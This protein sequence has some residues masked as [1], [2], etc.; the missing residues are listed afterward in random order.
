M[1]IELIENRLTAL[2]GG[3]WYE[4]E[5]ELS[6]TVERP[7]HRVDQQLPNRTAEDDGFIPKYGL[8]LQITE[9][10]MFY[11]IYSE[12]YRV[13]GT[14]RGRGLDKG[15]PTLPVVY[16]S[17]IIENTEFGLK[18][19]FADGRV[20]FN[21][22]Y[23][24]MQWQDMQIEVTDPSFNLGIPFQIVV[25]NVGDA[26]VKG[27]DMELKALLGENLEV[28][29]NLTEI[30]DAYVEAPAFYDEPRAEGGKI[31]SGL[32][33]ES[34]LPLFADKS[35]S[36]YMEYSGISMAGGDGALRLQH[37]YVGESLNQLTDGAASAR[38]TQGDYKVTDAIFVWEKDD[39]QARLYVN[40]LFD[41]RGITY[42]DSQDFDQVWGRGSANVIRPR[43]F[44]FSVRKSW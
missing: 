28:G 31:A 41:E 19:S 39:W 30:A 44:G 22:V 8:E 1:D 13:G 2:I 24:D 18:T 23:Y 36:L 11:G 29:F 5:R 6:Y 12:G 9:D 38:L 17:D 37:S 7:D 33:A 40:N 16:E 42:N 3:R 43:N 10:V 4:V 21:A 15:G 25:G 14:N 34:A 26:T 32:E 27:F 20:I 35:Y